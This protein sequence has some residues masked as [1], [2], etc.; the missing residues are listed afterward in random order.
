MKDGLPADYEAT[1]FGK[2]RAKELKVT[3]ESLALKFKY[4]KTSPAQL[5]ID[6]MIAT[7]HLANKGSIPF[8]RTY[9]KVL[10]IELPAGTRL[11]VKAG[12]NVDGGLLAMTYKDCMLVSY[13]GATTGIATP[14]VLAHVKRLRV[15]QQEAIGVSPKVIFGMDANAHWETK[16]KAEK[17]PHL[18]LSEL[19]TA[20]AKAD[21]QSVWPK[22]KRESTTYGARSHFQ[23]QLTKVVHVLDLEA[24]KN[25]LPF[26]EASAEALISSIT[27]TGMTKELLTGTGEG[28]T[29]SACARTLLSAALQPKP[30]TSNQKTFSRALAGGSL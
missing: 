17:K 29:E 8:K 21:L 24:S 16:G 11:R 28:V 20:T 7:Q 26:T 25:K 5:Q 6:D 19:E 9:A 10:R 13:H 14:E 30:S 15:A 1:L 4:D 27:A 12:I 22:G 18:T 23:T 2:V 3:K